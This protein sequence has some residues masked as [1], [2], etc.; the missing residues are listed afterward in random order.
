MPIVGPM[1]NFKNI[2][3]NLGHGGH[4]TSMS[5]ATAQIVHDLVEKVEQPYF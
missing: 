5:F 1:S 2:Y 3:L 4:G